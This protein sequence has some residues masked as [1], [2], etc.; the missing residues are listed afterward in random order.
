M[1]IINPQ[2]L[3]TQQT[4]EMRRKLEFYTWEKYLS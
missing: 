4:Q 2:I 3:E 1:E